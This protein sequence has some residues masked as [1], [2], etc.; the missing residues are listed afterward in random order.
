MARDYTKYTVKGLGENLNKRQLVFEIVKDYVEENKP[1]FDKL[2]SVFK[3][4]IQGS[5][6]FIRKAA[7][8]E[9]PKR[10]NTKMPLKIK[11]GVEVVV[12]NQW[13]SKNM[14]AFLSLAKKLKYKVSMEQSEIVEKDDSSTDITETNNNN[15]EVAEI[16]YDFP[17]M[18]IPD[19]LFH[20]YKAEWGRY[21][22]YYLENSPEL[23]DYEKFEITLD[24]QDRVVV[25]RKEQDDDCRR[26]FNTWKVM[27]NE[28]YSEDKSY[29]GA[30]TISA[31]DKYEDNW[32][33][34]D[35][36]R[37]QIACHTGFEDLYDGELPDGV[38]GEVLGEAIAKP[39][40]IFQIYNHIQKNKSLQ[41]SVPVGKDNSI[42]KVDTEK[43]KM[44]KPS[45][46]DLSVD[47]ELRKGNQELICTIKNFDVNRE[48]SEVK[49]MY[50]ALLDN[51]YSDDFITLTNYHLFKE[52]IREIYHEF[53]TNSYPSGDEYGYTIEDMKQDGF[54]WWEN[55]PILVVTRIGE[56]DLSPIVNFDEDDEI[57][58][59]MC[60][61][62]LDINE[63]DKDDC[64]D[65]ITD[66]MS[67]SRFSVDEDLFKE[68]MQEL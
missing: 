31:G 40:E 13:G 57:L 66:Y 50:D 5:K 43:S 26:W 47:I 24:M 51:F 17:T 54:D 42:E 32:L 15:Q 7:K 67:D 25:G 21:L 38:S 48:D 41:Y 62:M 63:D 58:L 30:F 44:T 16:I 27:I 23:E 10:F 28:F 36:F 14:D 11:F 68:V 64:E 59:N 9:D 2:S 56:I 6:G 45:S 3:D 4:E 60:C 19:N 39:D 33:D 20:N 12:S 18:K 37:W 8:V 35:A 61:E 55:D 53:L 34:D 49:N 22:V 1:S 46:K 52:F 29:D 65:Y